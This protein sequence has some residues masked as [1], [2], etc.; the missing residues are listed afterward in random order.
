M[1]GEGEGQG[2]RAVRL[3]SGAL[4]GVLG[5][6]VAACSGMT[7]VGQAPA[8]VT[9]EAAVAA[10]QAAA[11]KAAGIPIGTST[12]PSAAEQLAVEQ[13]R[14]QQLAG[15]VAARTNPGGYDKADGDCKRVLNPELFDGMKIVVNKGLSNSMQ[16]SHEFWLGS[17][18][19]KSGNSYHFTATASPNE[20]TSLMARIDPNGSVDGQCHLNVSKNI[21]TRLVMALNQDEA[22]SMVQG[23]IEVRGDDYT[24][25]VK[26]SQGPFVS[27]N[28]FQSIA[29][30]WA[31][32]GE[33]MFHAGQGYT[34]LFGRAKYM[35]ETNQATLT[36]N[37]VNT[38][39]A[40]YFRKVSDT[41]GM[42]AEIDINLNSNESI[43]N[44][45][46]DFL[47]RQARVQWTMSTE[48]IMATQ[49]THMVEPGFSLFLNAILDHSKD[50]H[51]FGY[52]VQFG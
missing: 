8:D 26:M 3:A 33:G 35:D 12:Q 9:P 27:V 32:G 51:R 41:L 7:P 21:T 20:N 28:Y 29:K 25:S 13:Q 16:T 22:R 37:T 2:W 5:G 52:G 30:N 14:Q 18:M 44:F 47:F 4:A 11:A 39:S 46:A 49:V 31:L 15:A 23:D 19:L 40:S 38:L 34:H 48:G 45:G 1:D 50:T 36:Y 24:G 42:A 43:M 10:A 6:N 17:Q